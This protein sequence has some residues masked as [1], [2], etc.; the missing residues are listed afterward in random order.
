MSS[1][2]SETARAVAGAVDQQRLWSTLEAMAEVG[3]RDDGGVNRQALTKEDQ[4]ARALLIGWAE[5]RGYKVFVDPA[6]NLFVRRDGSED[7]PPILIGSH[8]D[9]QPAG[10]RYDGIYGVLAAY[11]T[12]VALDDA[13]I[14]TRHPVEMVAWT[15]EEGGRFAC[16]CTGSMTWSG[17]APLE[18]FL[19]VEGVDGVV[20]RDALSDTLAA[21]PDTTRRPLGGVAHAYIEPHIEQGPV[22]EDAGL[23]V[24]AVTSIQGIRWFQVDVEGVAGHAGTTPMAGRN[25]AFQ[26]ALRAV[27]ALGDLMN[28]PTDTVRF[29]VGRVVV[30]PNS[31]NTIPARAS[32]T[33]DFR[34][35]D[36]TVLR[37]RGDQ[38]AAVVAAAV[39][40]CRATVN[41]TSNMAPGKFPDDLVDLI[42]GAAGSLD[43]GATRLASGAFH[44]ALFVS[45]VC[46]SGM[47]FIPCRDGISHHPSEYAT[48]EDCAAGARVLAASATELAIGT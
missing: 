21:T 10:G 4:T 5:A 43:I 46:P 23:Q 25:D 39:A 18:K 26:A 9:S 6:A 8:M 13:G 16:G 48:P 14:E 27:T 1:E 45:K 41:E 32:F 29:T 36:E 24:A 15:N 31:P 22:L 17:A 28:D 34:H 2:L 33:I 40:P 12:L 42:E 47:I 37:E 38:I 44:D 19:D 20:L 35:P 11:E 7:L 30:E 3:A